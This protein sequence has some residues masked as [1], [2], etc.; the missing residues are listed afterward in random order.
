MNSVI[1]LY[2][3]FLDYLKNKKERIAMLQLAGKIEDYLVR[4]FTYHVYCTSGGNVFALPNLGKKDENR[5]DICLLKGQLDDPIIYGM[6][7]VKYITNN[8]KFLDHGADDE[9]SPTLKNLYKQLKYKPPD[10]HGGYR[11]DLSA[12]SKNIYGLVFASYV[13]K[14]NNTERKKKFYDKI[15]KTAEKYFRYYD[16][17]KPYFRQIFD[18]V[19]INALGARYYVSLKAGLWRVKN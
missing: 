6:I 4:E 3:S 5:I 15:L 14:D 11:V 13:T 19:C 8:H 2:Y 10:Q 18:D 12:K 1:E 16:L 7:E 9:I 17:A